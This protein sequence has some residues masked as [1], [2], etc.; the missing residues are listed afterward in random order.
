MLWDSIVSGFAW[1]HQGTDGTLSRCNDCHQT[2]DWY[3]VPG[4]Y[5]KLIHILRCS[6]RIRKGFQNGGRMDGQNVVCHQGF[7]T[8]FRE[9]NQCGAPNQ[10]L[11]KWKTKYL[12]DWISTRKRSSC[13]CQED[14]MSAPAELNL[15]I[16][17]LLSCFCNGECTREKVLQF[18]LEQ[19]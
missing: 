4:N 8:H 5:Q 19:P 14:L 9:A 2:D 18:L 1:S 3:A 7:A 17:S 11:E 15:E 6:G 13:R 12:F 10:S 16:R